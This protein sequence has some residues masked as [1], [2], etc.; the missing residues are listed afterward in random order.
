MLPDKRL[1]EVFKRIYFDKEN[2]VVGEQWHRDVMHR[3]R[4]LE[5]TR[6]RT[7]FLMRFEQFVWKLMPVSCLLL[8]VLGAVVMNVDLFSD[9]DMT[10]ILLTETD[11]LSLTELMEL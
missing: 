7:E 5:P 1:N 2:L 11:E 6:P 8:M 3:I 10:G 4:N 9:G